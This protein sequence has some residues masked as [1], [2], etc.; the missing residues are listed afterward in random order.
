MERLV[1]DCFRQGGYAYARSAA[2]VAKEYGVHRIARLASNENPRPPSPGAM[3][4]GCEA[5]GKANRYPDECASGFRES[6][7]R[8]HGDYHFVTGVGMD[9]IIE[10]T[11]RTLV[12]P[13]DRVVI[14]TPTFSFYRLAAVAQGADVITVPRGEGFAVDPDA[15]VR[16]ASG[17]KLTFLCS[18]NNPTGNAT[19]YQVIEEI[20]ERIDGVLFLDNAY[21]EFSDH[22]YIPLLTRY[23]NLII[24]RTMSKI[25]SLAGLRVGYA[26]VPAWFEPFYSRAS[27]PHA[28]NSVSS[29]AASAALDDLP[30]LDET[31]K[32]VKIWRERMTRACRLPV[33]PSDANFIMVDVAPCTGDEMVERLASRGVLVRSCRSFQGLPDHYIR[34]SVGESWEN[35]LFL[36]EINRP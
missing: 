19:P 2:D 10:T 25:F 13:G 5:L 20:L 11:V 16:A 4:S 29:A 33:H 7:C 26:M 36:E 23:E 28:L 32:H 6:L 35:E 18:P 15:L 30:H 12:D 31:R 9:G 22:D 14:S 1:R 24:G 27:T 34:V 21:V 17:S 3:H 8:Y